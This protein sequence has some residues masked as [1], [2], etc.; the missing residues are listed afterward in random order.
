MKKISD[1]RLK[2]YVKQ[3]LSQSEIARACNV[4]RQA[5]HQ[6]LKHNRKMP[7]KIKLAKKLIKQKL[8]PKEISKKL[9]HKTVNSTYQFFSRYKLTPFSGRYHKRASIIFL[10]SKGYN[11][12][13]IADEM[14]P[15]L[16]Y[17]SV[18]SIA[19]RNNIKVTTYRRPDKCPICRRRW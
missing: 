7:K 3:G 13:E 4:S 6:R 12:Q 16:S 17:Q 1:E 5:V 15:V 8:T 14:R 10:A 19:K 9:K 18:F 2:K 11:Y